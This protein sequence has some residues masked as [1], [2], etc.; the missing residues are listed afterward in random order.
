MC[1][2]YL[3]VW[4]TVGGGE[5][6]ALLISFPPP[7]INECLEGDFCFPRGECLNT[8]GSY[9]CLCAQGFATA[10]S[11]ASCVG[12]SLA[13]VGGLEWCWR[14]KREGPAEGDPTGYGG[15]GRAD[16]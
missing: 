8:E 1:A 15:I 13:T 2:G 9:T 10:P 5:D 3:A 14:G 6:S 16:R 7:D 4:G 12:E 11:G